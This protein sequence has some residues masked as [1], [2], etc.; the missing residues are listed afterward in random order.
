MYLPKV[1]PFVPPPHPTRSDPSPPAGPCINPFS[2][3]QTGDAG[4]ACRGEV[5]SGH[6]PVKCWKHG[7][8]GAL[9]GGSSRIPDALMRWWRWVELVERG[10]RNCRTRT[11]PAKALLGCVISPASWEQ[12][13]K[14]DGDVAPA[15][16]ISPTGPTILQPVRLTRDEGH[17]TFCYTVAEGEGEAVECYGRCNCII[18]GLDAHLTYLG[19]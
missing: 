14:F 13:T 15:G 19:R 10:G 17:L 18:R 4:R 7:V 2:N 5:P 1:P 3:V 11:G 16:C 12:Y 9:P 6:A 8:H